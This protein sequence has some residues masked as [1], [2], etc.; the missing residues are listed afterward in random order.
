MGMNFSFKKRPSG[1]TT[2]YVIGAENIQFTSVVVEPP[3][4]IDNTYRVVT[5]H[6]VY[7]FEILPGEQIGPFG[8]INQRPSA[9]WEFEHS[10]AN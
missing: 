2:F 8:I 1:E 9:L 3:I 5:T 10:I 4:I 7:V 6:S